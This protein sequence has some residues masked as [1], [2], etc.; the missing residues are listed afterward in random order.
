MASQSTNHWTA[1]HKSGQPRRVLY[2]E[3][4]TQNGN[5]YNLKQLA[6][7]R[8]LVKRNERLYTNG[9]RVGDRRVYTQRTQSQNNA[10][11][12]YR[13]NMFRASVGGV[14]YL[15]ASGEEDSL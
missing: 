5:K 12:A 6:A 8:T 15:P 10:K 1:T 3:R 14:R 2:R 11:E 13:R 4:L 9:N 7:R